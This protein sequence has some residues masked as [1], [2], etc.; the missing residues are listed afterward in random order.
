MAKDPKFLG[1]TTG[2]TSVLHTWGQN[3]SF[4]PRVHCIVPGGR[5]F[6]RRSAIC[7]FPQEVLHSG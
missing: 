1:A 5:A 7:P 3:L 4:H 6:E 2:V